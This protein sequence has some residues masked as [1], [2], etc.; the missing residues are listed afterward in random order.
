MRGE[1]AWERASALGVRTTAGDFERG[2]V[3]AVLRELQVCGLHEVKTGPLLRLRP[4]E[5]RHRKGVVRG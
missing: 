5:D 3:W 2:L 1:R 4:V